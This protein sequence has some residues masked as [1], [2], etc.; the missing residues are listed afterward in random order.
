MHTN[1]KGNWRGKL[2]S[3][4]VGRLRAVEAMMKRPCSRPS[5]ASRNGAPRIGGK[6]A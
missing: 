6:L 1:L 2:R 5:A 3:A 4:L